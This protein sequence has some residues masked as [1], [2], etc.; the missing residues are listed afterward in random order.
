MPRFAITGLL[1]P[2][3]IDYDWLAADSPLRRCIGLHA[4]ALGFDAVRL[5]DGHLVF[6][7]PADQAICAGAW[8]ISEFRRNGTTS[9]VVE[10]PAPVRQVQCR[11]RGLAGPSG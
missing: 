9:R 3:A 6:A 4:E 10:I 8:R 7:D 1:G 2:E 11:V 5:V